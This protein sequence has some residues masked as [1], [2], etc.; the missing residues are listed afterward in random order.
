MAP[1]PVWLA[2]AAPLS[3]PPP[4][5]AR[6]AW[7]LAGATVLY[8]G[9][10]LAIRPAVV[11]RLF[12]RHATTDDGVRTA[13]GLWRKA[14]GVALFG[15][16]PGFAAA[17]AW[18]GGLAAC[19]LALEHAPISL[20]LGLGFAAVMAPLIALQTRKPAFLAH[21]PEVRLPFTRR[22]AA[23]NAVGWATFLVA[24]E[25]FFRGLLVIALA[26]EI[27]AWPALMASLFAYVL[28]HLDRFVGE[29]LGTLVTG[30]LFGLVALETGSILG[31]IVAH[32]GVS[33]PSD[34][35]AARARARLGQ[36]PPDGPS[37][38]H[39]GGAP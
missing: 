13:I 1:S 33:L 17:L 21:Y 19:G 26:R 8:L 20:A 37:D 27:G 18:P 3:T 30:T 5:E 34:T 15:L 23:W 12:P 14:V 25:L 39:A 38:S 7:L 16:V 28:A 35:L 31:P 10:H 32:L 2:T 29:T 11:R 22:V 24:Y 9:Y 4:N 36:S 6:A